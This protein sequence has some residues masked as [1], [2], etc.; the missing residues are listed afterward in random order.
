MLN[1]ISGFR[2]R[3]CPLEDMYAP[4][5]KKKKPAIEV[6]MLDNDLYGSTDDWVAQ[7]CKNFLGHGK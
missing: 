6:D 2:E 3:E 1:L 7:L 4:I 5:Q